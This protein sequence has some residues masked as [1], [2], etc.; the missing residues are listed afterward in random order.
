MKGVGCGRVGQKLAES[1]VEIDVLEILVVIGVVKVQI[2]HAVIFAEF[3]NLA[4][5]DVGV[6]LV[7]LLC[8]FVFHLEAEL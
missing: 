5:S 7:P 8:A 1:G 6:E 4:S 2:L 3:V